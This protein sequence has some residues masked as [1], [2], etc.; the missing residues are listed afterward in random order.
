MLLLSE[1]LNI[2]VWD[3][4]PRAGLELELGE[5]PAHGWRL[6]PEPAQV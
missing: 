4:G 1:Q 6:K 5:S 2:Q 3:S